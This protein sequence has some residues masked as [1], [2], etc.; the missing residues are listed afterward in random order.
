M[1]INPILAQPE[2]LLSNEELLSSDWRGNGFQTGSSTLEAHRSYPNEVEANIFMAE[3][4]TV[5]LAEMQV[6]GSQS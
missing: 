2:S 1:G 3:I 4:G 5:C 6:R